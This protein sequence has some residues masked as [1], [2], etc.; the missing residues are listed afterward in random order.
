[1]EDFYETRVDGVDGK[2]IG[3]FGVFDGLSL[4]PPH[5]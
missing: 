2:V 1:M 5:L 4:L 3:L